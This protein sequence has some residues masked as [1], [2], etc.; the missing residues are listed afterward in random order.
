LFKAGT[1]KE[2]ERIREK[3]SGLPDKIYREALRLVKRL[4]EA[5]GADR[6]VNNGDGGF[7]LVAE[8]IQDLAL[9]SSQYVDMAS[10]RHEAV[11]IVQCEKEPWLNALFLCNNEFGINVLLPL[12]IAPSALHP[13]RTIRQK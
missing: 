13:L 9:I 7:V 10:N 3:A 2:L 6:D 4:D 11:S 5:Y 8:N 12:A 1:V